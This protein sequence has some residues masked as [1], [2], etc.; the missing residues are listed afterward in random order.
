MGR[1]WKIEGKSEGI[2]VRK[3]RGKKRDKRKENGERS[4]EGVKQ[5]KVG[6]GK[7]RDTGHGNEDTEK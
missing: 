5:E 3:V 1:G 7:K 6:G 4:E 2:E